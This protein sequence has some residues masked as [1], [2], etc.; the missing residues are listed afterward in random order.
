MPV[1]Y[2]RLFY[3]FVEEVVWCSASLNRLMDNPGI[4]YISVM[5]YKVI[6]IYIYYIIILLF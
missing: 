6:I 5:N 3:S 2:Y 1:G 4:L